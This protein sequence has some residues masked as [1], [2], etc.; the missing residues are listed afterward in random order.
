MDVC[1]CES[2]TP[3]TLTRAST[4]ARCLPAESMTPPPPGT[5]APP[6]TPIPYPYPADATAAPAGSCA[7]WSGIFAGRMRS[8]SS[9]W[10]P[11]F[12]LSA[13]PERKPCSTPVFSPAKRKPNGTSTGNFWPTRMTH[14]TWRCVCVIN[15]IKPE[16]SDWPQNAKTELFISTL[17]LPQAACSH[18]WRRKQ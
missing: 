14:L 18:F 4:A 1:A 7:F 11:H 9:S 10:S 5:G 17:A 16:Q 13:A 6:G 12:R 3:S 8:V 15:V 2:T